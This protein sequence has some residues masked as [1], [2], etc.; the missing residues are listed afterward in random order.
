MDNPQVPYCPIRQDLEYERDV[1]KAKRRQVFPGRVV[2]ADSWVR[3]QN[4]WAAIIT[5][6]RACEGLLDQERANAKA[7]MKTQLMN[8]E[9]DIPRSF[10]EEFLAFKDS[11]APVEAYPIEEEPVTHHELA[12]LRR[13]RRMEKKLR[14]SS[15]KHERPIV[16]QLYKAVQCAGVEVLE[17]SGTRRE[18]AR[19]RKRRKFADVGQQLEV[20]QQ[21][22]VVQE[23][24]AVRQAVNEQQTEVV[25]QT[26]QQGSA[27]KEPTTSDEQ[28]FISEGETATGEDQKSTSWDECSTIGTPT[29]SRSSL[30]DQ[31]EEQAEVS[32]RRPS[33]P[34]QQMRIRE[35]REVM[36]RR[37]VESVEDEANR[38]IR[39]ESSA[40]RGSAD[41]VIAG[42]RS[43]QDQ[44][45]TRMKTSTR[46]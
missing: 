26:E 6:G 8:M 19:P 9:E 41:T 22:E 16:E 36:R 10:E 28:K 1:K 31:D 3:R 14:V 4:F 27:S 15:G 7:E 29:S 42:S 12:R 25:Q 44:L 33:T 34:E 21:A 30:S 13:R 35:P 11:E 23:A 40:K 46:R 17:R 24:E 18:L 45:K 5:Q 2:D 38:R 43:A 39:Q 20:V 32:K 37:D